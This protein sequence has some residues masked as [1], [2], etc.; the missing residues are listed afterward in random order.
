MPNALL[1]LPVTPTPAAGVGVSRR[2]GALREDEAAGLRTRGR[3]SCLAP[4]TEGVQKPLTCP[5]QPSTASPHYVSPSG[6]PVRAGGES[7][8]MGK[9]SRR[10]G[11]PGRKVLNEKPGGNG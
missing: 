5:P 6:E 10:E 11:G 3:A 2:G 7:E 8:G 1:G 4:G 9:G